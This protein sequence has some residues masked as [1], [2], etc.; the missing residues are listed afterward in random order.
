MA[1]DILSIPAMLAKPKRLFSDAKITI[2]NHRNRLGIK[3]IE[4]IK[5]LKS[6]L[7]KGSV[8]EFANNAMDIKQLDVDRDIL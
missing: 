3:S 6:W 2:T 8:V 1:L 5:C 4:A 7:S